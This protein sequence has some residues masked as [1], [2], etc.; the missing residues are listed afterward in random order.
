MTTL[1]ISEPAL[2]KRNN[3]NTALL[4]TVLALLAL[5][6][7]AFAPEAWAAV[8]GGSINDTRGTVSKFVC[9]INTILQ[10]VSVAV[11]TIAIIFSGYQI[12]FAN[13]RITDVAPIFIGGL[14]IGGAGQ[15]AVMLLGGTNK[16]SGAVF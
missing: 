14:I 11:V 4:P 8:G 3:Y 7:S 9:N 12:A 10:Y 13:K 1:N 5:F 2:T 15:I 6:M 16:C